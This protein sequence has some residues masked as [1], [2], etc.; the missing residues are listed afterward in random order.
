MKPSLWTVPCLALLTACGSTTHMI[1]A[2]TAKQPI[3]SS[4]DDAILIVSNVGR[5]APVNLFDEKGEVVGQLDGRTFTVLHHAPG[6]FRLYSLP[7]RN[8][9]LGD[10]DEGTVEAGK[11]YYLQQF[12]HMELIAERIDKDDWAER[13]D[14]ERK[15]DQVSLDA[16]RLPTLKLELGDVPSLIKEID[17][18]VDHMGADDKAK[19]EVQPSDG[20]AR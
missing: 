9:G 20:E 13:K 17:D 18:K 14:N 12:L 4:K 3:V 2:P 16:A 5:L 19:R 10:R 11:V 15:L 7:D 8:T 6:A 1:A